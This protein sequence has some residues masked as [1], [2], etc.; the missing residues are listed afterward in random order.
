VLRSIALD[1]KVT[2]QHDERC[3]PVQMP[4]RLPTHCLIGVKQQRV[5][6][7]ETGLLRERCS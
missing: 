4:D 3:H 5:P 7:L 1:G 2:N 6:T